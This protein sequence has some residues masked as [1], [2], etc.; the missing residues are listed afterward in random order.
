MTKSNGEIRGIHE[1]GFRENWSYGNVCRGGLG[2]YSNCNIWFPGKGRARDREWKGPVNLRH[3]PPAI[4]EEQTNLDEIPGLSYW[5]G[6]QWTEARESWEVSSWIMKFMDAWLW[7]MP[8]ERE[9]LTFIFS[10]LQVQHNEWL[11]TGLFKWGN[12][13]QGSGEIWALNKRR[14]DARVQMPTIWVKAKWIIQ[15][16]IGDI[17]RI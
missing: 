7:R 11:M 6:S 9:A 16:L 15:F 14:R 2:K 17:A 10:L 8:V 4:P 13:H 1:T 12:I 5:I 3:I